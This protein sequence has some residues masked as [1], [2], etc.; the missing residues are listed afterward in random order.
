MLSPHLELNAMA[1]LRGGARDARPLKPKISSFP[2]S[3]WEKFG[4]NWSNSMLAHP[5]L[6]NPGSA[7]EMDILCK[8]SK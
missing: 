1:D 8:H 7:T 5:P 3:L 6:G 4:K 2:C